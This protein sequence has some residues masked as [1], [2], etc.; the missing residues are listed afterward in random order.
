MSKIHFLKN[1]SAADRHCDIWWYTYHP[2]EEQYVKAM[3]GWCAKVSAFHGWSRDAANIKRL[4]HTQDE[5]LTL[6]SEPPAYRLP[7]T[8]AQSEITASASGG[9]INATH[10]ILPYHTS[11]NETLE[12]KQPLDWHPIIT[13]LNKSNCSLGV[14]PTLGIPAWGDLPWVG[15]F[16]GNF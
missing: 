15:W 1:E 7:T 3:M 8:Q 9:E 12:L 14:P 13:D 2:P 10:T 11:I 5:D 4:L 6:L 16:R